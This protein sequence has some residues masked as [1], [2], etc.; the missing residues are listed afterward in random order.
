M[1]RFLPAILLALT[2][3]C[4]GGK[5]TP[6]QGADAGAGT[7]PTQPNA[8]LFYPADEGSG[9]AVCPVFVNPV[10]GKQQALEALVDRYLDGPACEGQTPAFPQGT[11]V[12]A[13]Y[14]LDGGIA[15]VDLTSQA[16]SGGGTE[17]EEARVYGLVDTI[18]FNHSDILAVRFLVEGRE[19]DSL[20][21]HL[22]LSRPLPPKVDLM[23]AEAREAYRR[24]HGG[25]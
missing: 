20:M 25:A 1:A 12:R 8:T 17:A 3:A 11:A 19:V 15:V 18:A 5:G 14:L 4:K 6:T 13:A 24:A 21:G 16:R 2:L 10:Q 7:G 23:P 22:D 9:L